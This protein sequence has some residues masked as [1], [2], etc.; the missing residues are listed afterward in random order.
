MNTDSLLFFAIAIAMIAGAALVLLRTQRIVRREGISHNMGF[1]LIELIC[2]SGLLYLA[3][4][5]FLKIPSF[6][7]SDLVTQSY[8]G[9]VSI[10]ILYAIYVLLVIVKVR[11]SEL[12]AKTIGKKVLYSGVLSSMVAWGATYFGVT[13]AVTLIQV[14]LGGMMLFS[15][16]LLG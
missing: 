11:L 3:N 16:Q 2:A 13:E 12:G 5:S 10:C 7:Q 14:T 15:V 6:D 1:R 4:F 9:V 8:Y